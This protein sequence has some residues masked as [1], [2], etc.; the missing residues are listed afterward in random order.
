MCVCV[1]VCVKSISFIIKYFSSLCVLSMSLFFTL[2]FV[3][4]L[5][6]LYEIEKLLKKKILYVLIA[7]IS[8]TH[9]KE[10]LKTENFCIHI[11]IVSCHQCIYLYKYMYIQYLKNN[12]HIIKFLIFAYIFIYYRKYKIRLKT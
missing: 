7:Q 5:F 2:F 1:C 8:V 3:F 4:Y 11:V 6:L 9:I 12:G 10:N